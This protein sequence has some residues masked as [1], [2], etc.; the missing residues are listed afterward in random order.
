MPEQVGSS[1]RWGKNCQMPS[2]AGR[3]YILLVAR[4]QCIHKLYTYHKAYEN[5]AKTPQSLATL[6][7]WLQT[8]ITIGAE[9]QQPKNAC[10]HH[11]DVSRATRHHQVFPLLLMNDD[12]VHRARAYK[13]RG[14]TDANKGRD[15]QA[16]NTNTRQ[17]DK[18]QVK[19]GGKS[20]G[21]CEAPVERSSG[22]SIMESVIR[23]YGVCVS[24][25][26]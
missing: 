20:K 25:G 17:M 16:D 12:T 13:G 4:L 8:R 14:G 7:R 2:K 3:I 10:S 1:Q 23:T 18:T 5:P 24:L 6:C 26:I 19:R 15:G 21:T 11:K 22:H 9:C